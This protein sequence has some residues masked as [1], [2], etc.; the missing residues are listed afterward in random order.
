[1]AATLDTPRGSAL[2]TFPERTAMMVSDRQMTELSAFA[3][4]RLLGLR[5]TSFMDFLKCMKVQ[6]GARPHEDNNSISTLSPLRRFTLSS[7][8][9]IRQLAFAIELIAPELWV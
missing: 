5:E 9:T 1:M 7:A 8:T 2:G 4:L 6:P 3:V